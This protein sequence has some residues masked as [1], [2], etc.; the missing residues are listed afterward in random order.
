MYIHDAYSRRY[1]KV[2][3][4]ISWQALLRVLNE[5]KKSMRNAFGCNLRDY[6]G[7]TKFCAL[8]CCQEQAWYFLSTFWPFSFPAFQKA[9]CLIRI[10]YLYIDLFTSKYFFVIKLSSHLASSDIFCIIKIVTF[11]LRSCYNLSSAGIR[12]VLFVLRLT[13]HCAYKY[14]NKA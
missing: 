9:R 12:V 8:E 6:K 1:W 4:L 5:K 11:L 14:S 3:G 10:S 13:Q 2:F 7:A